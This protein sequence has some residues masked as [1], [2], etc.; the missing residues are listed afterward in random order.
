MNLESNPIYYSIAEVMQILKYKSPGPIYSKIKS[1][2]LRS[3][4]VDGRYRISRKDLEAFMD[5]NETKEKE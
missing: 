5:A 4:R 1:K 3:C 2:R